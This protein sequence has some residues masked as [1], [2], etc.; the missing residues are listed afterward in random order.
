MTLATDGL[1]NCKAYRWTYADATARGAA[2]GFAAADV[3]ALALQL[4]D[5]SLWILTDDSP[6]TWV[7]VA[8][9]AG[10]ADPTTTKGDLMAR[11]SSAV[12]RLAVG[13]N[14]QAL[15]AD[16]AAT[17]GVKWAGYRGFSAN[18]NS[19]DQSI[20][21]TTFT[22]VVWSAED[23]DTESDFDIATNE[24]HTPTL[25]GKWRYTGQLTYTANSGDR[26]FATLYKNG[27]RYREAITASNGGSGQSH[28][29]MVDFVADMNGSTDYMELWTWASAART[30]QGDPLGTWFQGQFL[31]A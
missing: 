9:S 20:P 19:T 8:G 13:S 21:A 12:A 6:A 23:W 3:G 22:K 10:L 15:V 28:T 1:A 11:S 18:K 29:V 26:T 5:A 25:A 27:T 7:N 2:S 14:G 24:R 4:D 30:L 31:G 17:L 16:S